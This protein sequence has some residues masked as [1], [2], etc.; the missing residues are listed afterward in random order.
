MKYGFIQAQQKAYPV[1]ALCKVMQVS[2]SAYYAW[3]KRPE[4]TGKDK[5]RQRLEQR[6]A[7]IFAD[8]RHTYGSRRLSRE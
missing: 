3:A 6:A 7:Q 2:R 1:T 4:A 8:S 5:E